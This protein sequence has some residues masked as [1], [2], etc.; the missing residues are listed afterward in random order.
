MGIKKNHESADGCKEK[1]RKGRAID[2]KRAR[3]LFPC[4]CSTALWVGEG[5]SGHNP[6]NFF[7]YGRDAKQA[8]KALVSCPETDPKPYRGF[9]SKSLVAPPFSRLARQATHM[10]SIQL[11]ANTWESYG[12]SPEVGLN[13]GCILMGILN[14]VNSLMKEPIRRCICRRGNELQFPQAD[15]IFCPFILAHSSIPD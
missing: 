2:E 13:T 10:P 5:S 9:K 8:A 1:L 6:T 14:P 3:T 12:K 4:G 15:C 11:Q 7:P